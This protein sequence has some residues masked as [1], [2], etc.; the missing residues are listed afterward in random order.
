MAVSDNRDL[1]ELGDG[2]SVTVRLRLYFLAPLALLLAVV[3]GLFVFAFHSDQQK[4]VVRAVGRMQASASDLYQ[5]GIRRNAAALQTI[6]SMLEKNKRLQAAL[7]RGD[8]A[9]LLE[10]SG[11]LFT[12]LRKSFG[13]T[14]LYFTR[15]DRVNLLRVH[16]PELHGDV[17]ERFTT[18]EA[19]RTGAR[20]QG[21]ELGPLGHLRCGWWPPGMQ[22][23]RRKS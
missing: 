12:D 5:N 2:S 14:H 3:I 6:I 23:R 18:R 9:A 1:L 21:L 17:I 7:A 15:P 8:R 13:V 20:A 22:T 19:Q 16:Q 4:H 11:P 10:E